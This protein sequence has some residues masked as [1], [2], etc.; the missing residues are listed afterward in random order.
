V[1]FAGLEYRDRLFGFLSEITTHTSGYKKTEY[2]E[3][4]LTSR[5]RAVG[6][7]I[8]E[9]VTELVARDVLQEYVRRKG[10][11]EFGVTPKQVQKYVACADNDLFQIAFGRKQE[12]EF[13]RIFIEYAAEVAERPREEIWSSLVRGFIRG[14]NIFDPSIEQAFAEKRLEKILAAFGSSDAKLSMFPLDAPQ[15]E[16]KKR[17]RAIAEVNATLFADLAKDSQEYLYSLFDDFSG[18][19]VKKVRG[20]W[21]SF[22]QMQDQLQRS[23]TND[24]E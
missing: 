2:E 8:N 12:V 10:S 3:R 17:D 5:W 22:A 13:V 16:N 6:E 7:I 21:I 20:D 9:G 11:D 18:V 15:A 1:S 14:G 4:L 24:V 23:S 19:K